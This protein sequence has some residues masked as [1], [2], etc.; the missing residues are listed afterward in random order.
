MSAD[1]LDEASPAARYGE[2]FD[3]GYV[4]Y[5][6]ERLGRKQAFRSLIGYS[7]KRAMGIRKRW[8]AKVLPFLLYTAAIIPLVVMIG[9]S[10]VVPD[11]GYASYSD[12][13]A[14]IFVIVGIFVAA[15]A[16]EMLCVDRNERTLPLYFSRAITRFDY[17]LAK[18]IAMMLL[19]MTLSL[20]PVVILWLGRQLVSDSPGQAIRDNVGDLGR[21]AFA[22]A[23]IALVL[24]T[25]GLVISSFTGRKGVAV[26]IIFI[27]FMA[28][29][30]IANVGLELLEEYS[31]S[32]YLI[33]VSILDTFE[34]IYDHI[35][36]DNVTGSAIAR[37]NLS[38]QVYLG[39]VFSL[40]A[41]GILILRWRYSPR[42]DA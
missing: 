38:L 30:S 9:I 27:G 35:I 31:W 28:T 25:I 26:T 1:G 11:A 36:D 3:R 2:V 24:G 12:Y 21:V 33:L 41:I 6:G 17:V 4:H 13:L 16:P 22:G 15:T 37:A 18:V 20:V 23:L 19:T 32:R 39:Y 5:T 10:A 7:I 14:S 40:V 29:T 8:T 34:G 42:D